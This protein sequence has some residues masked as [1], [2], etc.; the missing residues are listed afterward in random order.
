MS[1]N[2]KAIYWLKASWQLP[3]WM[4]GPWAPE[5][6]NPGD[7]G[8]LSWLLWPACAVRARSMNP[9]GGWVQQGLGEAALS[10]SGHRR[11]PMAAQKQDF[12]AWCVGLPGFWGMAQMRICENMR[13]HVQSPGLARVSSDANV[14]KRNNNLYILILVNV[15]F[16][17][18]WK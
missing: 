6:G 3:W 13:S 1:S 2:E 14:I 5:V 11:S 4:V 15:L 8:H 9:M 16:P 18:S 12:L 10:T 7:Q 17:K